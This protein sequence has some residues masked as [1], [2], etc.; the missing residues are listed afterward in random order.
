[1][2]VPRAGAASLSA[3]ANSPWPSETHRQ[4]LSSPALRVSTVTLSATM[5]LAAHAG[6]VVGYGERCGLLVAGEDD[7][8]IGVGRGER[9]VGQRQIAQAVAGVRC[10][11]DKLAQED[12]LIGVQCV[13]DDVEQPAYFSLEGQFFF[14]H[15]R[16]SFPSCFGPRVLRGFS[17]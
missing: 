4:P 12:L 7:R 10:V 15:D 2:R 3:M 6:A 16:S 1:M 8:E 5:K 9:R 17:R 13:G 11:G 14:R